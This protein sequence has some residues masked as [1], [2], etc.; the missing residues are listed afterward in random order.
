MGGLNLKCKILMFINKQFFLM[1]R[2]SFFI[3][4]LIMYI[5]IQSN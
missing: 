3:N 5:Y 1:S 4:V 2:T